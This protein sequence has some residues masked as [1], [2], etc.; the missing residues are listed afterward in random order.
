MAQIKLLKIGAE[1]L[2][3]E[4]NS[5]SDDITLNSFTVQGGGPAMSGTGIDMQ[6]QDISDLSDLQFTNPAVGTVNQTAGALVIDDIMAKDRDNVMTTAGSVLFPIVSDV[7]GQVD[8]FRLP[9]VAGA[10]TA[11]PTV[12]GEGYMVWDSSNDKL[13]VWDGAAWV[14]QNAATAAYSVEAS[15]TADTAI[16]AR[17]VVYISSADKVSPALADGVSLQTSFAIG[18]AIGAAAANAPVTVRTDGEI[19]GFSGLTPGARLYLSPSVAGGLTGTLPTGSG[20]VITQVGYARS[21]TA[22]EIAIQALGRRA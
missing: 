18:F 8:A 6:G 22:V 14:D 16:S 20:Q 13:Y 17:D 15:F 9:Q 5:A 1:G 10:P 11:S 2:P 3:T 21:A 4:F 7:S 12:T 19:T